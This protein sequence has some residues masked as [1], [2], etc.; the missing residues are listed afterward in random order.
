MAK[1][2]DWPQV[3]LAAKTYAN[4]PLKP[5]LTVE[6]TCLKIEVEVKE[7]SEAASGMGDELEDLDG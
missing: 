6:L 7:V 5:A 2:I 4:D 1:K 3:L